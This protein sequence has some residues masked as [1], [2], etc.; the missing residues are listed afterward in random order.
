MTHKRLTLEMKKRIKR[1]ENL[2]GLS[3]KEFQ[4]E[5]NKGIQELETF[6]TRYTCYGKG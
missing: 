4:T 3:K 1:W 6:F 2:S 5:I